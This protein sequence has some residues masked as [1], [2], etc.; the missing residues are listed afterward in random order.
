MD[1]SS[2]ATKKAVAKPSA[3]VAFGAK[4]HTERTRDR[5]GSPVRG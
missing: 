5:T 1:T 2:P 4:T 3:R